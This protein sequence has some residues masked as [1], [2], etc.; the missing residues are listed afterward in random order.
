[1]AYFW[2][3]TIFKNIF[4]KAISD[5]L[6]MILFEMQ[7]LRLPQN[8]FAFVFIN[9]LLMLTFVLAIFILIFF[10]FWLN[11]FI[12]FMP[13]LIT[14][15]LESLVVKSARSLNLS[16]LYENCIFFRSIRFYLWNIHH[17]G[18]CHLLLF[19]LSLLL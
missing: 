17:F 18:L 6:G 2:Q 13:V 8:R 1:M 15:I 12:L 4:F 11:L 16:A 5:N 14:I 19:W 10:M 3:G 9:I 7:G